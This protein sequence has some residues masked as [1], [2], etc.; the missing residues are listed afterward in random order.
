MSSGVVVNTFS[1]SVTYVADN[2]QRTL[3]NIVLLS[4]LDPAKLTA[5]WESTN[6]ALKTWLESKHLETIVLEISDA[7]GTTLVGRWDIDVSYSWS[8][9]DGSN[10]W[11]DTDQIKTAIKKAGQH[12][13]SC[14]YRLILHN[15]PGYAAVYGWSTTS[16]LSTSGFVKQS[17]GSTVEHSGL[18]ASTSYY[19]RS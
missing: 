11:V 16:Y 19:R 8:G 17:L 12:P 18:G 1:H 10:F 4:G 9:D 5:D 15:K 7:A 13:A 2:I 6:R 14:E 3:K